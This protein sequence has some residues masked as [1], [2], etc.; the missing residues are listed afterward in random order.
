MW[1]GYLG[2][3][4]FFHIKKKERKKSHFLLVL[5]L[6]LNIYPV[7]KVPKLLTLFLYFSVSY[8]WSYYNHSL[9]KDND[10]VSQTAYFIVLKLKLG[11]SMFLH[12]DPKAS[13]TYI[14][15][16]YYITIKCKAGVWDFS[17]E[18]TLPWNLIFF[19]INFLFSIQTAAYPFYFPSISSSWSMWPPVQASSIFAQKRAGLQ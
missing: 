12:P 5:I 9:S 18:F 17:L 4:L 7:F 8:V 6:T 10:C 1:V 16:M 15:I 19:I 11:V 13:S 14:T 3:F 2:L